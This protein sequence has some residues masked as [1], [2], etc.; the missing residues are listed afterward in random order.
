VNFH[1][2]DNVSL[3]EVDCLF[4]PRDNRLDAGPAGNDS[5]TCGSQTR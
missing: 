5:A 2:I 3:V 1:W 4:H